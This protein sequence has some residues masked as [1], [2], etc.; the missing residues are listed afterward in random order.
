ML[1]PL[2]AK[3]RV[4]NLVNFYNIPMSPGLQQIKWAVDNCE[5]FSI[6]PFYGAL[7]L[8]IFFDKIE[9]VSDVVGE[10]RAD[11]IVGKQQIIGERCVVSLG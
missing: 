2:G 8:R 10:T 3:Q 11:D 7:K 9:E 1:I 4:N 6:V 5:T